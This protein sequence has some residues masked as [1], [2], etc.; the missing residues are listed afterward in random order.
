[1]T[2]IRTT[3]LLAILTSVLNSCG[4]DH[5]STSSSE[6]TS[7]RPSIAVSV[8]PTAEQDP[9]GTKPVAF[10]PCVS[11]GDSV[12]QQTGFDPKTRKRDD[13]PHTGY[14]FIG[15]SFNRMSDEPGPPVRI[16]YLTISSTNIT[17]DQFRQQQNGN[18][19]EISLNGIRAITYKGYSA[20]DC[21]VVMPGPDASIDV[22]ISSAA[23]LTDWRACDSKQQIASAIQAA[24]PKK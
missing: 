10:D 22:D 13:K 18:V 19:E 16:G 24:L 4:T 5:S 14:D 20:E 8:E 1:M 7:T 15:C 21:F 2:R 17:L 9:D 12:I 6:P 23:A 3:V 11:I